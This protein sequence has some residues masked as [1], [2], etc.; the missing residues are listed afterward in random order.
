MNLD[1]RSFRL[2]FAAALLLLAGVV[3]GLLMSARL[4][5]VAPASSESAR[6]AAAPGA[7]PSFVPIAKSVMPAVV[8]ISTSRVVR[9]PQMGEG[10]SPFD[11]PMFRHFFGDDFFRRFPMPRERRESSLGSGVI[12]SGDGYIVTNSHVVHK[13][14]QIKVLLSDKREFTGKVIGTDP[15]TD[16]AVIKIEARSLPTIQW[17]DSDKLEVGEY[18][19]AVG[20]PFGLNQTV[21][22]GIVSAIGRADVGITDY[23]DFI[24][25][26]AA[27]N[28]GNSGG[29][30]INARGELIGINTAIFSRS[31][32][33][34]GIGFAVPANLT[35]SIMDSLIKRGKVVRGYIG[36]SIAPVTPAVAKHLGIKET[37][38]AFV[39][40]ILPDG[41]AG[42][43]G[44]KDGD[45]IV[46]FNGKSIDTPTTLRNIVAQTEIGKTVKLELLRD[47]KPVSVDIRIAE[48][49]KDFGRRGEEEEEEEPGEEGAEGTAFS[50]LEVRPLTPDIAEQLELPKG[51]AGVVVMGAAPDSVSARAGVRRG[52]VVIEINRM[53]V[54]NIAD[55]KRLAARVGKNDSVML[56]VMRGARKVYM[57]LEP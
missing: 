28:P 16:I 25:T 47:G 26:D 12:V 51:T 42:K 21:T 31:G 32:G 6:L 54:R 57:V 24:Q 2:G 17:G 50:G 55:F 52:D 33:Y 9:T 4:D 3:T 18:V 36:V 11:D 8:N 48:Q 7:P 49:P 23:E 35:R 56:R 45:V 29:A 14:D 44:V 1:R 15:K 38:G 40:E 30:L 19:L 46:G 37:R 39:Q 10:Q 20:N 5:W 13:V 27:I 53:P 43:A 22:M 41:P 34:Q